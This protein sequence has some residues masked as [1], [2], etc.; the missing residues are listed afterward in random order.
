MW[1]SC[2]PGIKQLSDLFK[3]VQEV[4]PHPIVVDADDLLTN[5]RELMEQ[6]CTATGL[7]FEERMLN[8]TPGVVPD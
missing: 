6:Y 7:P 2:F 8:W 1:L 5:V 4:D 3:T